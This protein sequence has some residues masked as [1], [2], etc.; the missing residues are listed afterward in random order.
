M[1]RAKQLAVREWTLSQRSE[2]DVAY[3]RQFQP[4][5]EIP[6][7]AGKKLLCFHGSPH[8][9]DDVILPDTA[10]TT[11]RQFLS[12]FD[13]TLMTG[14]HTHTQQLRRLVD[15]WYFNP[16]GVSLAYNWDHANLANGQINVDP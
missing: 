12:G 5:I 8:S 4:T 1:L 11:V 6:L 7:Q 2:H 14:G 16:G 15:S 10:D 13:A 3:M 9:F